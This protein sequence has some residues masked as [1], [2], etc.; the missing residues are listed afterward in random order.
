MLFRSSP[1]SLYESESGPTERYA[2]AGLIDASTI[3][4]LAD[5][6]PKITARLQQI[7]AL[8]SGR[9][10]VGAKFAYTL[11]DYGAFV[12]TLEKPLP[13]AL[14]LYDGDITDFRN[15][16]LLAAEVRIEGEKCTRYF[17]H[18]RIA[19][20]DVGWK[21]Q[22]YPEVRGADEGLLLFNARGELVAF[23]IAQREKV[24][25]GRQ[26][27]AGGGGAKLTPA[28]QLV[29]VK[30]DFARH[31]DASNVPLTEEQENRLA[32][33][34]VVLQPLNSELARIN[35]VS[36]LTQNGRIGA[37]VSYVYPGSPAE[38]AKL[39]V[40]DVLIRLHVQDEP[41]PID[42]RADD[43][44][45]S[46]TPFPWHRLDEV[47]EQYY[48]RIPRPWPPAEN[49]L[50]RALT[51]LGFGKKFVAEMSREGN[52]FRVDFAVA[53]SPPHYDS[54]PKYKSDALGLTVRN[55]TYEVQRYFQ[56]TLEDPGVIVSKIE[57]GSKASVAGMKP[58]EI[59]THV[60]D[61]PVMTVRDFE[62]LIGE[63]GELRLSV[64]RMTK[65][66]VVKIDTKS[67]A[68]TQ[69]APEEE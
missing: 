8:P 15:K 6:K 30:A 65:G 49:T 14:V 58:Y 4:V 26:Y 36:D 16:L 17:L 34:G 35:K 44:G 48:D 13:G 28:A 40:G 68:A 25:V 5:L 66:R 59:I 1:Y 39:Q 11:K 67:P 55:L 64:K 53:E 50:A 27:E 42:V 33:L 29:G 57:P 45:F 20:F 62:K 18:N 9:K 3:L 12:A 43:Y 54:A 63:N 32:W 31:A 41:K 7:T 52:V 21:R 51:D 46:S 10:P 37:L 61:K 22:L 60:N 19:S 56:K 69:P 24:A 47:P 38:T 23:P 2:L